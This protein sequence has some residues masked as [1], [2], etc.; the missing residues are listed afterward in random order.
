M[1][2]FISLE[3]AKKILKVSEGTLKCWVESGLISSKSCGN[4]QTM[5]NIM[6]YMKL[7]VNDQKTNKCSSIPK[8]PIDRFR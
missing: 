7:F 4:G 1:N 6:N 3:V 8:C 2:N 5:Y